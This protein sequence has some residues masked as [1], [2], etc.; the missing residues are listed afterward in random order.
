MSDAVELSKARYT[1]V[2]GL[3]GLLCIFVLILLLM[4][5]GIKTSSSDIVAIIGTVTGLVGT[6]VG[7]F[8]GVQV[9][10]TDKQT[11]LDQLSKTQNQLNAT[12]NQLNTAQSHLNR[13]LG[14]LPKEEAEKIM[15]WEI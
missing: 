1:F 8:L 14:L 10:S 9:G 5:V 4:T 11:I 12:Q 3:C 7:A 6:I 15:L 13:A 2:I